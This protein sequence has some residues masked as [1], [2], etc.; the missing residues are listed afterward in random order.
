MDDKLNQIASSANMTTYNEKATALY[1]DGA[2]HLKH[3]SLRILYRKI[4]I[5]IYQEACRH[6]AVPVVLDLGAG[7]GSVTV[8]FLEL[9]AK[10]VAVDNSES[11]LKA[12][13][14]KCEHFGKGLETRLVD[15]ND[16]LKNTTEKY[17]VIVMNSFLHHVPDYLGMISSASKLLTARGCIFTFQDPL[18]YDSLDM[19][20]K[21]FSAFSYFWWRIFQGDVIRGCL[22]R[23]RR[24]SGKYLEDSPHDNSEYHVVRNGVNQDAI[25]KFFNEI[26]FSSEIISYFSTQSYY[27]QPLGEA[28]NLKNTFAVIAKANL[29][30]NN[31]CKFSNLPTERV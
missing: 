8:S 17:D 7:E 13:I 29:K 19:S 15:A 25:T 27:F 22:R 2:P 10:V 23:I 31:L 4:V 14:N 9:G 30:Y 18:R 24:A 20:S 21:Y 26:G 5:E 3:E 11:Q 28:L 6:S 1:A 12:L 16:F